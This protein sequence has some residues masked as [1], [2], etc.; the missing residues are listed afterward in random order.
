MK[1]L[2]S[3]APSVSNQNLILSIQ[4]Y[5]SNMAVQHHFVFSYKRLVLNKRKNTVSYILV[6]IHKLRHTSEYQIQFLTYFINGSP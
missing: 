4:G 2:A 6:I 3:A 1:E 5:Y